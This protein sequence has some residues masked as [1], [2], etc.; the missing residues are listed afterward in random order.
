MLQLWVACQ[1]ETVA[2]TTSTYSSPAGVNG[3]ATLLAFIYKTGVT[4]TR[5]EQRR[6]LEFDVYSGTYIWVTRNVV[7]VIGPVFVKTVQ[8]VASPWFYT[9]TFD[10]DGPGPAPPQ[11]ISNYVVHNAEITLAEGEC[12]DSIVWNVNGVVVNP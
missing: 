9:V 11:T 8:V 10:P 3:N 2:Q 7:V 6:E 5:V 12:V 4:G 1:T